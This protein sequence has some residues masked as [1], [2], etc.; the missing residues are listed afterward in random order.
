[1]A[2]PL[3]TNNPSEWT[4]LDGVYIDE[5]RPPGRIT[6]RGSAVVAI[7]GQFEMGPYEP[8]AIGGAAHLLNTFGSGNFSGFKSLLSK[9]FS[10]LVVQRIETDTAKAAFGYLVDAATPTPANSVKGEVP[11]E[12]AYGNQVKMKATAVVGDN[13]KFNLT[14]TLGTRTQTWLGIN[15][16]SFPITG[17]FI[18]LTK[19]EGATAIP[20]VSG[21]GQEVTLTQGEDGTPSDANY[22]AALAK[23][24]AYE[25]ITIVFT[26]RSTSTVNTALIAHCNAMGDRI[27]VLHEAVGTAKAAALTAA[28]TYRNALDRGVLAWPW[29]YQYN[30]Q[31]DTTELS[32][33]AA[34]AA[35]VL[36]LIPEEWDPACVAAAQYLAGIKGLEFTNLTRLDY[37]ELKNRGIMAFEFDKDLGYKIKSGVTLSLDSAT[38]MVFRRRMCDLITNDVGTGLK[39]Y[40]NMPMTEDVTTDC[41]G[42]VTKYLESLRNKKRIQGFLVDGES[43]NT[44]STMANGEFHILIYVRLYSSMRYIVLHAQVGETVVITE[45]G[46]AA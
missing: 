40:Q 36:S 46:S 43:M 42:A 2:K 21:A 12:G 7:V 34:W 5:I 44:P 20:N 14:V 1:M 39:P 19:A 15:L 41:L 18:N 23:L 27:P 13:T 6:T 3:R 32:N 25:G 30:Y 28:D 38:C 8:T 33:P 37:I 4:A 45:E 29:V 24:E 9:R 35:S 22:T 10:N 16:D 26:D 31:N 17:D 11:Y